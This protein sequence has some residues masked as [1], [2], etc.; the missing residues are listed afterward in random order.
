MLTFSFKGVSGCFASALEVVGGLAWPRLSL[1]RGDCV[2]RGTTVSVCDSSFVDP[3]L[4]VLKPMVSTLSQVVNVFFTS[5]LPALRDK[6]LQSRPAG[7]ELTGLITRGSLRSGRR[8]A[9][10]QS[11]ERNDGL[12]EITRWSW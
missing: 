10:D 8:G 2:G 3:E 1:P 6:T 4:T 9:S 11:E 12:R 7:Q 5:T